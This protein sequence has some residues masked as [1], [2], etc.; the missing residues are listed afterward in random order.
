MLE[1]AEG[2]DGDLC[3]V[4]EDRGRRA[5]QRVNDEAFYNATPKW[6]VTM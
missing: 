3:V 2:R 1:T 5:E 6:T 4:L